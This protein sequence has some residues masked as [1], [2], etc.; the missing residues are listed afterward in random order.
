MYVVQYSKQMLCDYVQS[1]NNSYSEEQVHSAPSL[2]ANQPCPPSDPALHPTGPA[3]LPC[4]PSYPAAPQPCQPPVPASNP[5]LSSCPSSSGTTALQTLQGTGAV[6][7]LLHRLCMW[8]ASQSATPSNI[9]HT[10]SNITPQKILYTPFKILHSLLSYILHNPSL[11]CFRQ[12][13][14]MTKTSS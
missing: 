9:L 7:V 2:P 10:P 6:H 14:K 13:A 12:K 11:H 5:A 1:S 4:Q 8:G 3:T